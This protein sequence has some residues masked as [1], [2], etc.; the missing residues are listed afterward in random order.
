MV[1]ARS[2]YYFR[3]GPFWEIRMSVCLYGDFVI[4]PK[5]IWALDRV[6]FSSVL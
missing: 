6:Q 5:G 2:A 4:L 1:I 3:S